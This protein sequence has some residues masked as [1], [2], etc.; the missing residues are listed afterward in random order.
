METILDTVIIGAGP[1]GLAVAGSLAKSRTKVLIFEKE[2]AVGPLWS[3]HY[4][5][6]HLH[7]TRGN[8]GLPGFPIPAKS[9]RYLPRKYF[10]SYLEKYRERF[11]LRIQFGEMVTNLKKED[12]H[13][14]VTTDKGIYSSK[15]VVVATGLNGMPFLP[16]YP[17]LESFQGNVIHSSKYKNGKTY[18]G[19]KT[20]VVGFGNSGAEIALDLAESKADVGLCIRGPV[21]VVPRDFFGIPVQTLAILTHWIPTWLLDP[22]FGVLVRLVVGDLK[23]FGISPPTQG[24]NA[25]STSSGRV[26]V[27]DVGTLR[28]IKAG[29]ISVFPGIKSFHATEVEFV[30]GTKKSCDSVIFATGY[31]PNFLDV[32]EAEIDSKGRPICKSI[33]GLYF[34][35]FYYPL[36]GALRQISTEA[37]DIARSIF[38]Y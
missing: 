33:Q 6:L 5:R 4:D 26:P 14:K 1:A 22:I 25:L 20:L 34:I 12:H 17:G 18:A 38:K 10:L 8:S 32:I 19:R 27:L 35:G 11:N 2:G 29:E 7:T 15:N 16:K 13:W 30:D 36:T 37:K 3:R 23:K 28:K 21:H 31:R 24:I 9:P